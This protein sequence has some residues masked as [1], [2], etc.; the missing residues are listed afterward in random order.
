MQGIPDLEKQEHVSS[1]ADE[2]SK[3]KL[4]SSA[5]G[6]NHGTT[7]S[8]AGDANHEE[9]HVNKAKDY[10]ER[11]GN[12]W[13]VYVQEAESHDRALIETWKDDMEG[14]IIFAG[15]YS[16]SL[17]AFLVESYQN[18]QPNPMEQAAY[19]LNQSVALLEQISQQ[20]GPNG[21]QIPISMPEPPPPFAP[22]ASDVRINVF[23]FMSLV[24][25]L[26]AALAATIVQQ[27]YLYEGAVEWRMAVVVDDVPALIHVSLFLF[28]IG[29]SDFLFTINP[30]VAVMT[31]LMIAFCGALYIWSMIAPVVYA[32]SPYQSPTSGMFWWLVQTFRGRRH[33][34][35]STYGEK[36]LVSTN[37]T[38]GR[39][40]LA[41]DE[42]DERK[43]RDA[44][45]ICWVIDNLTED[46]ELEPFVAGIPGSDW[47]KDVWATVA[48]SQTLLTKSSEDLPGYPSDDVTSFTH[49]DTVYDLSG[50]MTRLLKTCT[51]SGILTELARRKR[52]R[53]CIDAALSL[54][55]SMNG[56]NGEWEWFADGETMAQ[57]LV[58]LGGI[59]KI[60]F[61]ANPPAEFD[62][63]FAARWT[64]MAVMA[65]RKMLQQQNVRDVADIV[66]RRLA[67]VSGE[68]RPPD[69]VAAKTAGIIDKYVK[70]AWYAA[71]SLHERL[72]E[73]SEPEK[74]EE[75]LT[76]VMAD[77]KEDLAA[78]DYSWNVLGW[79]EDVDHSIMELVDIIM[80]STGNILLHLPGAAMEWPV[81]RRKVPDGLDDINQ[82]WLMPQL[83]PPQLLTQRLWLCSW[84]LTLSA[85]GWG[86]GPVQ[87]AT[88]V[89]LSAPELQVPQLQKLMNNTDALYRNQLS[90]IQDLR[91][92]ALV[93]T[94]ELFVTAVRTSR[95]APPEA[96][97]IYVS[98][99]RTITAD[100][101]KHRNCL[102][103]QKCLVALLRDI[104]PTGE[105][106]VDVVPTFI[107]D[108]VLNLARNLL[109]GNSADT[110][111]MEAVTLINDYQLLYPNEAAL[112]ALQALR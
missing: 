18:L 81:D 8:P 20:L 102:G 6:V 66:V 67:E 58:Y 26:A 56:M 109:S 15:L 80:E 97:P 9:S 78:L 29:L 5:S 36:R 90:R 84:S 105:K 101:E 104:L 39:V 42:S 35:R 107:I 23:R 103:T 32:H 61:W 47:G 16:A 48:Q 34:D 49:H 91:D 41:M 112:E 28:F 72:A 14:I 24:F 89:E 11:A 51:D 10:D 37:M 71:K 106:Q 3:E 44:R 93:Y 54:V 76:K 4:L 96:R 12:L 111:V 98:T 100:W 27:Q 53:A 45:A 25:S 108:E 40:E 57:A 74:M 33:S 94:L 13:S 38:D 52:A 60:N 59:E 73:E 95:Y 85:S 99:L 46:S 83:L 87:P 2:K 43:K 70:K 65:T 88:L 30:V 82:R 21:N 63:A 86:S 19:S 79:A 68:Q 75:L 55:L 7:G 77:G 62:G 22:Q 92:G 110:H 31:I 64:C 50:R 69:E 1:V 17:T